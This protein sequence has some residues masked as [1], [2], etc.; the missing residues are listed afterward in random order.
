MRFDQANPSMF[1][2]EIFKELQNYRYFSSTE[3]EQTRKASII[4]MIKMV[5]SHPGR[6]FVETTLNAIEMLQVIL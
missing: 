6:C 4:N 2:S 1:N 3:K 5:R